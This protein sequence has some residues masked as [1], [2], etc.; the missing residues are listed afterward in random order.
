MK[1]NKAN[2]VL[3][4]D[5]RKEIYNL[6]LRFPG[7]HLSEIYKKLG[8][9]KNNV[10]YHLKILIK[11]ELI[12]VSSNDRFTRYYPAKLDDSK[13][14]KIARLLSKSS[15]YENEN[16]ALNI[17]KHYIP[18]RKEKEILNLIRRPVVM[19]I[20]R[21]MFLD[22]FT[23]RAEIS[24][25]LKKHPTTITFHLNKLIKADV[26]ERVIQGNDIRY[27]I[28]DKED[29]LKLA[30]LY[31]AWIKQENSD[32]KIEYDVNYTAIDFFEKFVF[33]MFPLP[34]RA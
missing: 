27:K 12:E 25:Y 13:A 21:F 34:F 23:S 18:G 5:T 28:K 33:D 15:S 17:F 22:D 2:N 8:M 7:I 11:H 29:I 4:L 16:R 9:Q 26:I 6:I 1:N 10:D 20:I 14:E 31:F 3:K 19:S 30:F 24:K 32:G